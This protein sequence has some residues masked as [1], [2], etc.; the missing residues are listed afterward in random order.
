MDHATSRP[1]LGAALALL[2]GLGFALV[3]APLGANPGRAADPVM[4]PSAIAG[5]AAISADRERLACYD[6]LSGRSPAQAL[7]PTPDERPSSA[8]AFR[9]LW[10]RAMMWPAMACSMAAA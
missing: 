3:G 6:R 5:C 2:L 8:E 9:S 7:A 10:A 1:H 4:N